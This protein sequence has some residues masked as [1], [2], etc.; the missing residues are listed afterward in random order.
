MGAEFFARYDEAR[1]V[2]E[3]ANEVL[4]YD[5]KKIIF[6]GPLDVLTQTIHTQP[7]VFVTSIACFKVFSSLFTLHYSPVFSAGHSLGVLG[8][9]RCRFSDF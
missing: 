3:R 8:V 5:L 1:G 6:E 7:A 4:G 2:F 9:I